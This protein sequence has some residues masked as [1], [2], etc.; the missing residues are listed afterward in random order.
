MEVVWANDISRSAC[1]LYPSVTGSN[2]VH[3]GSI[4]TYA[5]FPKVDLLVGCYPCQGYSQGGRR[6]V[7]DGI[8]YLYREF[9]RALRLIRP[10]A[11]IV[12]NVNGMRFGRNKHLLANQLTRFRSAGY[13]VSWTMLNAWDYGVPQRRKRLF[14]V[15][16]RSSEGKRFFFPQ[17]THGEED[18]RPSR[19]TLRDAI[20]GYRDAPPGSYNVEPFHWYYMSRNRRPEWD[21]P[22]ACVVAHWRHAMLHPSSP[23]LTRL[24]PDK[25]EFS[26]DGPA[27]RMSYLESAAIQGFPKPEAFDQGSVQQRFQAIGNAVPPPLF[28]AVAKALVSQLEA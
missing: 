26:T 5:S 24:G 18:G 12:E 21:G 13:R 28:G 2:C 25:W 10:I 27:R 7:E 17:A 11:F 20:W 8:N 15:G 23:P 1:D 4:S 19:P 22:G 9:D 16:I 6:K 14:L 3:P